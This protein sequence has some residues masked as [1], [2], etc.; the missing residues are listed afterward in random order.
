MKSSSILG[1][2]ESGYKINF[3]IIY[4]EIIFYIIFLRTLPHLLFKDDNSSSFLA[5]CLSPR[6]NEEE[7]VL[8]KGEVGPL[9]LFGSKIFSYYYFWKFRCMELHCLF[10]YLIINFISCLTCLLNME[11]DFNHFL[12]LN[13][14][15]GNELN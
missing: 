8:L 1:G 4:Y 6:E 13:Y 11:V 12:I 15:L 9:P 5:D 10:K 3:K 7:I 2:Y 14:K